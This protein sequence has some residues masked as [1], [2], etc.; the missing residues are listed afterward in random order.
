MKHYELPCLRLILV[1]MCGIIWC[2]T[3]SYAQ[4]SSLDPKLEMGPHAVG[5]K[6][7]HQYDYSRTYKGK[8]DPAGN[9]EIGVCARPI[10]TCIWYPATREQEAIPMLYKEYV[11]LLQPKWTLQ[12]SRTV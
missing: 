12:S 10:Q 5:L 11:Y 7:I 9:L 8:Y 2:D 6:V 4:I 3:V 1:L